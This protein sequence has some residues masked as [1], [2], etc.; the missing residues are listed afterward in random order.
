MTICRYIEPNEAPNNNYLEETILA[1]EI[2]IE[3]DEKDVDETLN[4][5][6]YKDILKRQKDEQ[7]GKKAKDDL[8]G[9]NLGDHMWKICIKTKRIRR[10]L[11]IWLYEKS[12]MIMVYK[13]R[14]LISH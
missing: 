3:Y 2:T 12:S 7:Q 8:A 11:E 6:S 9:K 4:V 14:I 10:P 1:D 13:E 5:V